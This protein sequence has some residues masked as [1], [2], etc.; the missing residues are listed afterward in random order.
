MYPMW[1]LAKPSKFRGIT[2]I[3]IVPIVGKDSL[4][5]VGAYNGGKLIVF[6]NQYGETDA[7]ILLFN[8]SSSTSN[9]TSTFTGYISTFSMS[10]QSLSSVQVINGV[11]HGGASSLDSIVAYTAA[12]DCSL[13]EGGCPPWIHWFCELL[14]IS[15]IHCPSSAGSSGSGGAHG[16]GWSWGGSGGNGTNNTGP[17]GG[18][19][20]YVGN[21]GTVIT[22]GGNFSGEPSGG[23]AGS[24]NPLN[25][26]FENEIFGSESMFNHPTNYPCR[27]QNLNNPQGDGPII[28]A[29][30]KAKAN[31]LGNFAAQ[32]LALVASGQYDSP[33]DALDNINWAEVNAS[34]TND[35]IDG[36]LAHNA[37]LQAA[38]AMLNQAE[39]NGCEIT[40]DQAWA[41]FSEH[42]SQI[43]CLLHTAH[44]IGGI[45][46]AQFNSLLNNLDGVCSLSTFL[47]Q[48]NN[49]SAAQDFISDMIAQI[50]QHNL[51]FLTGDDLNLLFN[52]PNLYSNYLQ[53]LTDNPNLTAN[54]KA[55]ILRTAAVAPSDPIEN[56]ADRLSCFNITSNSTFTHR[57]TL[58]VDQPIANSNLSASSKDLAGHT[59]FTME[60]DQGNGTVITLSLGLYPKDFATP[61]H[62]ID[63][64]AY[65]DDGGHEF[66]VSMTWP[67]SDW[68]F[69][70]L[71]NDLKSQ[72]FAPLYN[73]SSYNCA[74]F[75]I[76]KLNQL[77]FG[78]T[79]LNVVSLPNILV[80][81]VP[82]ACHVEGLAPGQLG[83]DLRNNCPEPP[84]GG[85]NI[86]GGVA[87][88][89]SCH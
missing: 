2:D 60:Q 8:S 33:A 1:Y 68:G 19:V 80:P 9:A 45:P 53:F 13:Y 66:D 81:A 77:G 63:G 40:V 49:S 79:T 34:N 51:A 37:L 36:S 11:L 88:T 52:N 30:L 4:V 65:N 42:N 18:G 75:A 38:I 27:N 32:W 22:I 71:V 74:T 6:K 62:Q 73:L 7:S 15:H 20:I 56:L 26:Y 14:G 54:A 10:G 57:I 17:Y 39:M 48:H 61:C 23:A 28:S 41:T 50:I 87:P 44:Q 78:I 3:L 76:E 58:F 35:L 31:G 55:A 29:L 67:I 86:I 89:S 69:N 83:Q 24:N 43:A 82:S 84:G 59:F 47:E 21:G 64:G 5:D 25:N 46:Q 16:G 72:P 12:P 70:V 85:K